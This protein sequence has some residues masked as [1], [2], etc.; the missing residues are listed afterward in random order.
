MATIEQTLQQLVRKIDRLQR[1]VTG[2][3]QL[4]NAD[5]RTADRLISVREA[6]LILGKKKS[7]VYDM[8]HSGELPARHENGRRYQLSF[9]QV[10]KYISNYLPTIPQ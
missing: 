6:C 9:N 10:Q 7:A 3:R 4:V 5:I 8:I 1:E 2:L